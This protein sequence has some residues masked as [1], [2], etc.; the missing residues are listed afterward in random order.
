MLPKI[1][2]P[3]VNITLP[4]TGQSV[5][6]RPFTVREEKILLLA[7]QDGTTR[8]M[9]ESV[10]QIASNCLI[11]DQGIDISKL[12][13]FD[14]ELIF[15]KLRIISLGGMIEY[16]M[17]D[18]A[19]G[20]V[21]FE[22]VEVKGEI[23]KKPGTAKLDTNVAAVLRYPTITDIALLDEEPENLITEIVRICIGRI[24][25]GEDDVYDFT[26]YSLDEQRDWIDTLTAEQYQEFST[27]FE[28]LP[29]VVIPSKYK[30]A[31]GTILTNEIKGLRNFF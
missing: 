17:K 28:N 2:L 19:E 1:D 23:K 11:P 4:S 6:F 20:R 15:I 8:Q 27:F 7:K 3:I 12:P 18:G 30:Q 26:N 14:V 24:V 22:D 25:E 5:K 10:V 16:K 31:D 29:V 21:N 13:Y 9:V